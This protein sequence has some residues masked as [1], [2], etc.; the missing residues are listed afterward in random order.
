M[1]SSFFP[2]GA[3]DCRPGSPSL[4]RIQ[5]M[6]VDVMGACVVTPFT[7]KEW[8]DNADTLHRYFFNSPRKRNMQQAAVISN[9][10]PVSNF[11]S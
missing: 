10:Y 8:I 11:L 3:S 6:L 1:N 4:W 5:R 9:K 2:L 7:P